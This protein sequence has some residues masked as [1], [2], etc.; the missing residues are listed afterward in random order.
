MKTRKRILALLTA[1]A[2]CISM[3]SISAFAVEDETATEGEVVESEGGGGMGGGMG[4]E[5]G[6]SSTDLTGMLSLSQYVFVDS[7]GEITNG[8]VSATIYGVYAEGDEIAYEPESYTGSVSV[9]TDSDATEAADGVTAVISGSTITISGVSTTGNVAYYLVAD[10]VDEAYVTTIYV[11]NDEYDDETATLTLADGTTVDLTT[12]APNMA[13]GDYSAVVGENE[14]NG[15]TSVYIG[16]NRTA[17]TTDDLTDIDGYTEEEVAIISWWLT[18]GVTNSGSS[19][20]T[21]GEDL[22]NFE[23]VVTMYRLFQIVNEQMTF[24]DDFVDASDYVSGQGSNDQFSDAV[25]ATMGSGIWNGIYT[26]YSSETMPNEDESITAGYL[27]E[28]ISEDVTELGVFETATVEFIYVGLY[29]AFQSAWSSLSEEG[30]AMAAALEAAAAEYDGGTVSAPDDYSNGA[31]IYAVASVIGDLEE[32]ADDDGTGTWSWASDY[33]YELSAAGILNG[34]TD[35]TYDADGTLTRAQAAKIIAEALGLESDATTSSFTD[36]S[37][38]H[39]ALKY[40]EACVEAG[41]INGYGDGTFAP[42]D[43][44]TRAELAK[45]IAV[46]LDLDLTD[47]DSTFIDVADNNWATV[48]IEACVN[49]GIITGYTDG[50]FL[51]NNTVTRGEAAAMISRADLAS[52]SKIEVISVLYEIRDCVESVSYADSEKAAS[53]GS[54][55]ADMTQ[56]FTLFSEEDT[57]AGLYTSDGYYATYMINYS[58]D[59]V[60]YTFQASDNEDDTYVSSYGWS[61][62]EVTAEG[63]GLDGGEAATGLWGGMGDTFPSG[64]GLIYNATFRNAY[65]REGVG[66]GVA[67]VGEDT[68]VTMTTTNGT[69]V[70]SGDDGSMAGTAYVAFGA[71]L[72]ITNAVAFSASQHL[73]NNLYNGTIHYIDS[74]A[75]GSGRLYSS[76]FW[77]GYQVYEDSIATGGNV[78]DEPTTL[79]VKNS[80]YGTSVGGNGYASQYFENSILNVSGAT[81]QNT[82]SLI[83]DTGSLTLVNSVMNNSGSYL[84]SATKGEN[85]IVTLVDSTVNMSGSNVLATID[86]STTINH[87]ASLLSEEEGGLGDEVYNALFDSEVAIYIYGDTTIYTSDGTLTASVAEGAT[88][89][90]YTANEIEVTKTGDGEIVYVV[91]DQYGTLTVESATGLYTGGISG[92][93]SLNNYVIEAEDISDGSASV[94]Y[95]GTYQPGDDDEAEYVVSDADIGDITVYTDSDETTVSETITA[96]VSDGTLTLSGLADVTENTVLYLS[97]YED[98]YTTIMYIVVDEYDDNTATLT[99]ADGTTVDLTT[100]APNMAYGDYTAVQ[101]ENEINGETSVYIGANRTAVTVEDLTDLDGYTDDQLTVIKWWLSAGVTNSGSSITTFGTDFYN[102]EYVV[103]MYRL[104]QIVNEQMTF[105]DEFVDASDYV[106]GMGSNDQFS[107]AVSA[108]MGSGIWNGIYTKY[109]SETMPNEDDSITAGYLYENISSDVT[110]LGVFET[111]TVEFIYVGLYNAFQS[112]WSSL[113]DEGESMAAA[114]EAAAASYDGGSVSA[115]DDYTNEAKIYA[116]SSVIMDVE[117]A[118]DGDEDLSKIEVITVL[119]NIRN[120]VESVSY[121]DSEKAASIGSSYADMTQYFTLF[122]EDDTGAGL[123]TSNGYYATYMINY[124]ANLVNYTF[125]ASNNSDDSYISYGWSAVEATAEGLGLDG[126]EA[127]TGMWGGMG[128][129]FPSGMGLIYNATFRNAFYREGVGSGVAI[130]GE[131]T[132]VTMTTTD[133]TLVLSGSGGS[134]AGTAYVAFGA[135]LKITNAVAF[136]S[137]Q[138]LTNNLY[139]GTIHYIDSYAI[140]QGRVYSSDFWGGYQVYENTIAT[141]GNVTDEPTTLIVKNSVYANSVGGNGFASQYFENSVLNVSGATFQDTTSLIT[142]TGSLT[143]VNS[144]MNDSGS[145]L[146]SATKG[147]NVIVTLVDSTVNM[148]GTNVLASIDAS[149]TI[150]HNASLGQGDDVYDALFDS[151]VAIYIYG[152]TTIVTSDGTLTASV[153]EGATLYIYSANLTEDDITNTGDGEIVVVTSSEYGTLTVEAAG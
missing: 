69:L 88:L 150:N 132:H 61:A 126:G 34:F 129:T 2:M 119:Y 53:I 9:Y 3:L 91:D 97:A 10:D 74:Y 124:S 77:G 136:S 50:T 16:A 99:L 37:D 43:T 107:D 14:I 111:A 86:A 48:Y 108:T 72:K 117:T 152:D 49:A 39:W 36:V 58:V 149:T 87:N 112:P 23:Y 47:S 90:I 142:D 44:V 70:L 105:T 56:Y 118:P 146:V 95:Y 31:K 57:G 67:I 96:A 102:F 139:N 40:I 94:T 13:Y 21:F 79:I 131:D 33:I 18:A 104:F 32:Y 15:E 122:S 1:L 140:G 41:I 123:Y 52:L 8:T 120:C 5:G 71:S 83:T 106:S 147:E 62:A 100:Y 54:S 103:T 46:A 144:V 133:G 4:G 113:S 84:V 128:D 66:S 65:Y 134:M 60:N 135:S 12:Y 89:Y 73:T 45:M 25:S 82:T 26:K 92:M 64:V 51:P 24:T 80:V 138:H 109:S 143:L 76:D 81:F 78:T 121:A 75:I 127:A 42:N 125:S 141:G 55:Y 28:N 145:Y 20:T 17:V 116:V 98:A 153:A 115:P 11:V 85:V 19:I 22:Y 130:V 114:L 27:Y 59:L 151:E 68:D 148:T 29:N 30:E 110:E 7:E 63:L 137:S 38:G 35:G 6:G 93:L 101:G